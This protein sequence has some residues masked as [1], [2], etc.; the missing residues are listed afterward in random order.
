MTPSTEYNDT[1]A[2]VRKF[3]KENTT[4]IFE[5]DIII[6]DPHMDNIWLAIDTNLER[7]FIAYLDEK[8]FE[9]V[10]FD[11]AMKQQKYNA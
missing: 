5:P 3:F 10:S 1:K 6:A 7:A 4:A 2:G 8:D 9:E 11:K